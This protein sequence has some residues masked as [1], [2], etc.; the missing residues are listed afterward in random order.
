MSEAVYRLPDE[1]APGKLQQLAVHPLWPL[2]GVMFGGSWLAFPWFAVNGFALGSATRV[3]ELLIAVS[4]FMGAL[5]A[6]VFLGYCTAQGWL[7]EVYI[8]YAFQVVVLW[9]LGLAYWLFFLQSTTL[10]LYQYAGGIVRNGV[11]LLIA[12]A[13]F[14]R[15]KV[16]SLSDSALW[17]LV[18]S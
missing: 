14:M 15:E 9:K 2:L 16:L 17:I 4:Y 11:F 1:P 8:K 3:K 6:V 10:E 18:V 7:P 13:L 12:A 5:L